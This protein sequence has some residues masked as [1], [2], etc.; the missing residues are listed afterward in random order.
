MTIARRD[1]LKAALIG[2]GTLATPAIAAATI[3]AS[4]ASGVLRGGSDPLL[5]AARA[6]LARHGHLVADR[7]RVGVIDFAL[8]S[9]TPRFFL[10]DFAAGRATSHLVAHGRGS[11]PAHRG[12]LERFSN[13]PGSAA[14]SEGVY[15]TGAEYQGQHGRSR[16][17]IGLDPTNDMAE[18]RAIVI[19]SAWYVGPEMVAQHGKL[20]RSEGC[21]AFSSAD[22]AEVMARLGPGHL[23]VAGRF[24]G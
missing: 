15:L 10:V 2:G 7:A 16:R 1:L 19:H 17:L 5:A 21:L 24:S 23:I 4:P 18:A 6:A 8:P 22:L 3:A 14:T 9:R 11:D 13:R 20:G 12:W